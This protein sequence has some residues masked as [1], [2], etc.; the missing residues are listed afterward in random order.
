[1]Q[2]GVVTQIVTDIR[3]NNAIPFMEAVIACALA[4]GA[5]IPDNCCQ[6]ATSYWNL[7]YLARVMDIL[8][9]I[10]EEQFF[11]V[12]ICL[13]QALEAYQNRVTLAYHLAPSDKVTLLTAGWNADTQMA[14]SK[15]RNA[16]AKEFGTP[17]V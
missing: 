16:F 4:Y 7:N 15:I 2:P 13:A 11:T 14:Y 8:S 6:S 10:N 1:M 3:T 17:E 5:K 12:E 9:E